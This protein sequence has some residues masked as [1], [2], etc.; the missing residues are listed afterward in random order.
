MWNTQKQSNRE[1]PSM[2]C[3]DWLLLPHHAWYDMCLPVSATHHVTV[4]SR[5]RCLGSRHPNPQTGYSTLTPAR[6]C[7]IYAQPLLIDNSCESAHPSKCAA[8]WIF[9]WLK[10]FEDKRA[11]VLPHAKCNAPWH[12]V[13]MYPFVLLLVSNP[14]AQ[15]TSWRVDRPVYQP[16]VDVCVTVCLAALCD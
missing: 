4:P 16:R 8:L 14:A 15:H 9:I 10:F 11:P 3:S 5:F 2:H 1:N 7:V 13:C 12:C 6:C